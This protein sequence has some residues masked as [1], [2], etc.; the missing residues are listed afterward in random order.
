MKWLAALR[1][2]ETTLK[3]K[4]QA[5]FAK[6]VAGASSRRLDWV[7]LDDVACDHAA[8]WHK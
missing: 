7:G 1:T 3:R 4:A 8:K 2:F 5:A 6:N